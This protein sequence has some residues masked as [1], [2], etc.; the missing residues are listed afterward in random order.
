[1]PRTRLVAWELANKD[2]GHDPNKFETGLLRH[3]L[4]NGLTLTKLVERID[5]AAKQLARQ[6][7]QIFPDRAVTDVFE[8]G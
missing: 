1:M 3:R 5:G 8:N 6:T 2:E 4:A 7:G